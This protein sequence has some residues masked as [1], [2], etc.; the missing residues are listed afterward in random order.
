MAMTLVERIKNWFDDG[1]LGNW[2]YEERERESGMLL[3]MGFKGKKASYRMYIDIKEQAEQVIIYS[4]L[5]QSAE[6]E[7]R[8][9]VAEFLTRANYGIRLGNFEMDYSDGEIRY[10]TSLDVS[11]LDPDKITDKMIERIMSA[12][13]STVERY[14]KGIVGINMGFIDSPEK[15]IAEIEDISEI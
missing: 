2:K 11:D 13:I 3:V 8:P 5:P 12:N 14:Y 9:L 1:S 15:A 6:E 7:K 10:K 4:M